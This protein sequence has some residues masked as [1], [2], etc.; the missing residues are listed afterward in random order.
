[1]YQLWIFGHPFPDAGS[2]QIILT[3][4]NGQF[5]SPRRSLG[6]FMAKKRKAAKAAHDRRKAERSSATRKKGDK[7]D[8]EADDEGSMNDDDSGAVIPPPVP[9]KEDLLTAFDYFKKDVRFFEYQMGLDYFVN[10]FDTLVEGTHKTHLELTIDDFYD[11]ALKQCRRDEKLLKNFFDEYMPSC[12]ARIVLEDYHRWKDDNVLSNLPRMV[13]PG[14]EIVDS[15]LSHPCDLESFSDH[16]DGLFRHY[17]ETPQQQRGQEL[18]GPYCC[19]VQSSGMGKTKILYEY[20]KLSSTRSHDPVLAYLI[21]PTV[22]FKA[23]KEKEKDVFDFKLNLDEGLKALK[24]LFSPYGNKQA[25]AELALRAS[26]FVFD[27]LDSMLGH[28]LNGTANTKGDKIALLFDESHKLLETEFG[29]EAFRFRCVRIWLREIRQ[30]QSLVA[31]FTGTDSKLTQYL[32]ESDKALQRDSYKATSQKW[33]PP[34]TKYHKQ[35]PRLFRTFCLTTTMASCL[36]LLETTSQSTDY[37]R[38]VGYGRPLFALMAMH[39][40]FEKNTP[41][42]LRRMIRV[43]KWDKNWT[44]LVNLLATRVPL[45]NATAEMA[46]DLS[47]HSYATACGDK[48]MVGDIPSEDQKL[49]YKFQ[50]L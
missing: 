5:D 12:N 34:P 38:S 26:M 46:S 31:V 50:S 43:E 2:N 22:A 7:D 37:D 36:H 49:L 28:L 20:K 4:D 11:Q 15:D 14:F 19:F 42:V 18:V 48:D 29:Y 45:G 30:H 40:L 25:Q 10:S 23:N 16:I 9:Y 41:Y 21:W 17:Y 35:G 8:R 47:A 24:M 3:I 6:P 13:S 27:Q 32:L 39:G 33:Q 1:M 44:A